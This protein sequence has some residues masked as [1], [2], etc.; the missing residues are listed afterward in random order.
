M[1]DGI[2]PINKADVHRICSGQVILDLSS[3]VKELVENSLDAGANSI[4]VRLK[5]YGGESFEVGDNGCGISPNNYQSATLK[6]HTSKISDF[7][8]LQSLT[9]LGFRGEALSS[10]CALGNVTIETR[11]KNESVGTQLI[12]DH[13][14]LIISQKNIARQIGTTVSVAKLFSPLPVRYK[15][16]HRNIRR[17]YSRL[18]SLL[19]AYA[20]IAKGVRLVCSNVSGRNPKIVVLRTQ[21]SGSVKDNIITVFG[22]KTL[23]CLTALDFCMSDGCYIEGFVSKPGSGSGRASG[24]RQFFYVNG[25]PVDMPKVTK[26]LNELYKSYNSQQYPMAVLNFILPTTTYDVNVT[27]DKRKIFLHDEGSIMS[28]LRESLEK[29]YSPNKYTYSIN[30]VEISSQVMETVISSVSPCNSDK[31]EPSFPDNYD[32]IENGNSKVL[33]LDDSRLNSHTEDL[34]QEPKEAVIQED[35]SENQKVDDALTE[36]ISDTCEPKTSTPLVDFTAFKCGTPSELTK[37]THSSLSELESSSMS[38]LAKTAKGGLKDLG[39]VSHSR[40]VQSKLTGFV[41]PNK[42]QHEKG[43]LLSE[44]PVLKKWMFCADEN[45]KC[46]KKQNIKGSRLGFCLERGD[47]SIHNLTSKTEDENDCP[48]IQDLSENLTPVQCCNEQAKY[49]RG[50]PQVEGDHGTDEENAECENLEMISREDDVGM[51]SSSTQIWDVERVSRTDEDIGTKLMSDVQ[52]DDKD[53]I[54]RQADSKDIRIVQFDINRCR[55]KSSRGFL[56]HD[57]NVDSQEKQKRHKK[58]CYAAATLAKSSIVE[59]GEEKEVALAAATRELERSFNK[60]D[61]RKMKVIGQFN[62]GFIIGKIDEDLFII[63][64]HASDEKYNFEHLSRT[65]ILNCQPLL[66]PLALELTAVEE[67]TISTHMDIFR[68]NGFDFAEDAS[69][70]PGRRFLLTSVPYS[71]NITFGVGDVQELISILVDEPAPFSAEYNDSVKCSYPSDYSCKKVISRCVSA[72]CPSRVRA[73]LASR[74][75]RKS[76]MIGDALSKKDMEMNV[77]AEKKCSLCFV[78]GPK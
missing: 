77:K 74:A 46:I 49:Q 2:R 8:D 16:F 63:D 15:E 42:R 17:E 21:G 29:I 68:R 35:N 12:F 71:R 43:S 18:L 39:L 55:L 40:R 20:L 38:S 53:N 65:T 48:A 11:T 44:E 14:G 78:T 60:E 23:A 73:M 7:S 5:E 13:S 45:S 76:V 1:M 75:C 28:A 36:P 66:R 24:D 30:N 58:R 37:V 57:R 9:L 10:L 6:Y 72:I 22:T 61:F 19:H 34:F 64:Q 32:V 3:A 27:P 67:V 52:L 41:T 56:R 59:D 31:Q 33:V 26:L 69:A 70:P 47:S 54:D 62:L 4:E 50:S 51:I 25:R